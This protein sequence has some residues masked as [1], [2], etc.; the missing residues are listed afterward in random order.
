MSVINQFYMTRPE[1]IAKHAE[2]C[3]R[4]G[5]PAPEFGSWTLF[6]LMAAGDDQLFGALWAFWDFEHAFDDLIDESDWSLDMIEA[7]MKALHD[8]VN[9]ALGFPGEAK[10]VSDWTRTF[11]ALLKRCGWT[12]ERAN[13]ALVAESRFF[14]ALRTNPLYRDHAGDFRGLFVQCLLRCLDGDAMAR[15]NDPRKVALAPAVKCGDLEVLFHLIYLKHG[16]VRA[17]VVSS[18][19]DYDRPDTED[20]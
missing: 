14:Q 19:R 10:H 3:A 16:W 9:R 13:L 15:S 11:V 7:A 2:L 5:E 18:L 1:E 6:E 8:E 20:K 12:A 4:N 17:R